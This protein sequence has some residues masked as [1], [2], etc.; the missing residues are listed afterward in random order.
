MDTTTTRQAVVPMLTYANGTA[1]M[2]WLANAFGFVETMRFVD[3]DGVLGHGEMTVNGGLLM[4]ASATP[5]YEG[6][7]AH[8]EHCDRARAWSQV[9]YVIDGVLVEVDDVDA[10]CAQARS[11]GATILSE[12]EDTPHGR[13]YR[14]EDLEGHRWMFTQ[15]VTR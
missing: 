6:P 11:A 3:D 13:L 15:P 14:A 7:R 4:L 12:P 5:A 9:P 10:H 1:A 2:D 8:R